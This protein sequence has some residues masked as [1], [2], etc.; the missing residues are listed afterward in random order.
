MGGIYRSQFKIRNRKSDVHRSI[1]ISD[2]EQAIN[3][4]ILFFFTDASTATDQLTLVASKSN[5]IKNKLQCFDV[6]VRVRARVG[7]FH[8]GAAVICSHGIDSNEWCVCS[9]LLSLFS[10]IEHTLSASITLHFA[11][12]FSLA[13]PHQCLVVHMQF[14]VAS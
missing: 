9:V 5:Q 12:S 3:G 7:D 10:S 8:I 1:T 2:W 14:H 11:L 13:P 4:K 6:R